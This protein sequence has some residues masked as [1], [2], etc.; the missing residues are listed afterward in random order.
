MSWEKANEF[1]ADAFKIEIFCSKQAIED[2]L[3][4]LRSLQAQG[5]VGHTANVVIDPESR[6]RAEAFCF[7]G[8]G[9]SKIQ[10]IKVKQLYWHEKF[11]VNTSRGRLQKDGAHWK[12]IENTELKELFNKVKNI[13]GAVAEQ[14]KGT[15]EPGC[16]CEKEKS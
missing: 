10:E 11:D 16:Q 15:C 9:S 1:Y 14:T 7:D 13:E 2:L 8:D 3:P 4:L 5:S 6:E 12:K